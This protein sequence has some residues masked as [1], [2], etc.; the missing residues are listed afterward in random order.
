MATFRYLSIPVWLLMTA[1]GGATPDAGAA[2]A[3]APPPRTQPARSW[4]QKIETSAANNGAAKL[5]AVAPARGIRLNAI[6]RQTCEI[7]CD[8][9]R[10]M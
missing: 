2:R 6:S 9:P 3:P 10:R 8:M 5:I 4:S 7:V 1:P